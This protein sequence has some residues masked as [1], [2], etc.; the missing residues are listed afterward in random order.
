MESFSASDSMVIQTSSDREESGMSRIRMNKGRIWHSEDMGDDALML[1]V[2][3]LFDDVLVSQ[4]NFSRSGVFVG[5]GT[6]QSW[7]VSSLNESSRVQ[8]EHCEFDA[9]DPAQSV[10]EISS[11]SQR[12]LPSV[13]VMGSHFSNVGVISSND[14]SVPMIVIDASAVQNGSASVPVMYRSEITFETCSFE[15]VYDTMFGAFIDSI[16]ANDHAAVVTLNECTFKSIHGAIFSQ[17]FDAL[18]NTKWQLIGSQVTG[19]DLSEDDSFRLFEFDV[20]GDCDMLSDVT[21]WVSDAYFADNILPNGLFD[22]DCMS[23][24]ISSSQFVRNRVCIAVLF[25]YHR[26]STTSI[27]MISNG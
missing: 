1:F 4:C 14:S 10:F 24:N 21:L 19:L 23:V 17:R 22:A 7:N 13:T 6:V 25:K 16:S 3:P 12:W 2:H 5:S 8:F 18:T 15:N 20:D 27:D 9:F 26:I 11:S